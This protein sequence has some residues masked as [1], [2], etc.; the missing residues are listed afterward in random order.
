[1]ILL[2]NFFS[3]LCWGKAIVA[4]T[5]TQQRKKEESDRLTEEGDQINPDIVQVIFVGFFQA[6]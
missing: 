1:M 2:Y 3:E 6:R 4:Y 5:K